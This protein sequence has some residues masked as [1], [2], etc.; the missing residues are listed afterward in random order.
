[1]TQTHFTDFFSKGNANGFAP[2]QWQ[3][4]LAKDK[5]CVNRFIPIGTG[6]GKTLGMAAAWAYHRVLRKDNQWPNRLVWCLPMRV[7]VEQT[8]DELSEFLSLLSQNFKLPTTQVHVL[9]GGIDAGGWHLS[10]DEPAVLV[11]TQDMLLSRALNRGYAAGRGRWPIDFAL[12]NQDCLWV[13][14]EVQLQGVGAVTSSQLQSFRDTDNLAGKTLRP[15]ATWLASATLRDRWV[16]TVDTDDMVNQ[17]VAN[18][19]QTSASDRNA[20]VYKATKRPRI[21]TLAGSLTDK[22]VV[23]SFADLIFKGH[24]STKPNSCGRVTLVVLN[25]VNDAILLFDALSKHKELKSTDLRLIHSR[26]RGKERNAWRGN[27]PSQPA[28]LSRESCE[29]ASTDRIIISTQVV[30]AGVD[31]SACHLVSELAPWSSLVQRFG[32]A[33][34]YGGDA[35][36]VVVD[37]K[38]TAKNALPYEEDE[39]DAA[40]QAYSGLK[41]VGLNSLEAA[42]KNWRLDDAFDRRLFSLNYLHLLLRRDLDDLFDTTPELTGEDID[43]SRFIREADDSS[44]R[45]AWY[46]PGSVGSTPAVWRPPPDFSPTRDQLCPAPVSQVRDWLTSSKNIATHREN[47]CGVPYAFRWSFDDGM[48]VPIRNRDQILPGQVLLV[49]YRCGGYDNSSG[50]LGEQLK[51]TT[52]Y[53]GVPDAIGFG[54]TQPSTPR[55]TAAERADLAQSLDKL[56]ESNTKYISICDHGV[57]VAAETEKL[58]QLFGFN[59]SITN[60]LNIASLWHDY[61]KC[62]PVFRGNI[63]VTDSAWRGRPDIAKAPPGDWLSPNSQTYNHPERN[64]WNIATRL[65]RRPGFRHELASTLAVLELAQRCGHETDNPFGKHFESVAADAPPECSITKIFGSISPDDLNLILYLIASHHG[66]IRCGM[67]MTP[68]DQAFLP[69]GESTPHGL[70]DNQQILTADQ[71]IET[72]AMESLPVRGVRKGDVLPS[73]ELAIDSKTKVNFPEV[74]LH[75]DIAGLGWSPRNGESWMQR[76]IRVRQQIGIFALAFLESILRSADV[77]VSKRS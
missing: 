73:I 22:K 72:V 58:C 62:H 61:G 70:N 48:W 16:R 1:M 63:R 17:A 53:Q 33:A 39:L 9:M 55:V 15:S 74:T 40:L 26:F 49:D 45:L 28:W 3:Q 75:T 38:L 18:Q 54:L 41:D 43:I 30:E 65:G 7:L 60:V 76:S 25:R 23:G 67:Q 51:L 6:L 44:V 12:L 71:K 10:I 32:R 11:G 5:A 24:R 27:K 19:I 68:D 34:R 21:T 20:P 14:D 36:I 66:K 57:E 13:L 29:D 31:I 50:F 46:D 8:A 69:P 47:S 4:D 56:S 77:T 37:R 59:D 52:N 2:Y 35:E 42:D 64:G